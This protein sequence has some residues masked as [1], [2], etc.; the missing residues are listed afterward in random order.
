[1][2]EIGG[3]LASA[4][5]KMAGDQIGSAI[6]GQIKLQWDFNDDLEDM[7]MTLETISASLKDAER[8]SINSAEVLL[9]LKRLKGAA[10]DIA[11]MID[12]FEADTEINP[13]APKVQ[14][15]CLL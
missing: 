10:Y 2:A 1:M 5:L 7:K 8:L 3:M 13:V 6:T 14:L 9:W 11:D 4:V 15:S 12:E